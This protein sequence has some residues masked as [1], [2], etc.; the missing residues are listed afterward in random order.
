MDR[1]HVWRGDRHVLK[2]VSLTLDARELSADLT[3]PDAV[4]AGALFDRV[5]VDAPCS[6]TGVIRLHPDIKLLRRA[7][8]VQAFV[9]LQLEI[10]RG[11]FRVLAPGGRLLY[12][13]C[14][15]LPAE[16]ERL[17]ASFLG[18]EAVAR[19]APMPA[20]RR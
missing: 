14:S 12:C 5:L 2:G 8:D 10:L 6:S 18:S 3:A 7:T 9:A 19:Q 15:L 11:A 4:L 20:A 17:V 1:V 13:T 16:N